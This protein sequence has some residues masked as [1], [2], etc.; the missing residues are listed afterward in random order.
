MSK[1][2][3]GDRE[4]LTIVDVEGET[5]PIGS[6]LVNVT[7]V[8]GV[9]KK[10]PKVLAINLQTTEPIDLT[11]LRSKWIDPVVNQIIVL[12][13][14]ADIKM[15]DIGYLLDTLASSIEHKSMVSMNKLFGINHP[16]ERTLLQMERIINDKK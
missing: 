16:G 11:Q 3:I 9:T 1:T 7:F 4:V 13:Q 8:D 6:S 5:T 10:Y 2:Y 14:E 12:M 15:D